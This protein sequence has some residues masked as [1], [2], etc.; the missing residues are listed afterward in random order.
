MAEKLAKGPT[1][2]YGTVKKLLMA[3]FDSSIE[4]QM[5]LEARGI[6]EMSTTTDGKEGIKAFLEKSKADFCG[7]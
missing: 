2:A 6:A 3:S 4:G 7:Q 1:C 5:E